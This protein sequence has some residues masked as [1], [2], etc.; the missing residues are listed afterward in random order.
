MGVRSGILFPMNTPDPEIPWGARVPLEDL[1][2]P[3]I[4][5]DGSKPVH[6]YK[7]RDA[8]PNGWILEPDLKHARRDRRLLAGGGWVLVVGLVSFG[9]VAFLIFRDAFPRGPGA[10]LRLFGL[11]A[12]VLLAGGIVGPIVTRAL[13]TTRKDQGRS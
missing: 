7:L 9:S 1:I 6:P 11:L 12:I 4:L 13:T 10:F 3:E 8:L 2:D 5:G